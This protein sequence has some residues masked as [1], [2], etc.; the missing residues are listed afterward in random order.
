MSKNEKGK[1]FLEK[2]DFLI[3]AHKMFWRKIFCEHK[4]LFLENDEKIKDL[5]T[6]F[7]TYIYE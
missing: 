6:F 2:H 5:G 1:Y 7:V 3:Y 4:F